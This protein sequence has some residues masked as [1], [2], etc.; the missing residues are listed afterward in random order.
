MKK[1]AITLALTIYILISLQGCATRGPA[2]R[3]MQMT[4]ADIPDTN[5]ALDHYIAWVPRN[6]A[7]T[8]AVAMA[9]T[10]ISM[11]YA[12]EQAARKFCGNGWLMD[13]SVK[14]RVGPLAITAPASIGS[15]PAWYYRVSLQPGLH[16]CERISPPQ[17]YR[18]IIENLP[19]WIRLEMAASATPGTAKLIE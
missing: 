14:E 13:E 11:G 17:L 9:Q 18:E 4:A 3:S 12:K 19:A 10:H 8:P 16:G 7:Q 2:S 1:Q 5:P 6:K 15:Y